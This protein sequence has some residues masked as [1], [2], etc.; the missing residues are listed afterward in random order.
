MK[1]NAPMFMGLLVGVVMLFVFYFMIKSVFTILS[2]VAPILFILA[3]IINYKTVLNFGKS[4][5]ERIK[6]NPLFGIAFAIVAFMAYP[7]TAAYLF[8][9]ALLIKKIGDV[10][11]NPNRRAEK[12]FVEYEEVKEDEDFLNLDDVKKWKTPEV[13]KQTKANTESKYDDLFD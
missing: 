7:F 12:E 13:V 8:G 10:V 9:K 6:V 5:V 1:S 4:M 2:W 3:L 11:G